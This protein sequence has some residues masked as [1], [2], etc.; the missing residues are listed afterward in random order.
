[1]FL[2]FRACFYIAF[3]ENC[4]GGYELRISACLK[5]VVDG[6]QEQ[7]LCNN[8]FKIRSCL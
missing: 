1:M 4:D 2:P 6:R 5:N 7:C 3:P 8:F